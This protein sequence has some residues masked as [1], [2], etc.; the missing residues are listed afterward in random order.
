MLKKGYMGMCKNWRGTTLIS[1]PSKVFT[2]II[3]DRIRE[4]GFRKDKSCTDHVATLRIIIEQSFERQSSI[5]INSIV[6]G[7]VIDSVD[8]DVIWMAIHHYGTPARFI[9]LIHQ[10]CENF[11]CQISKVKT[12][13]RHSVT[14]IVLSR[15][16][17]G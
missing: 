5:Y 3:F 2:R 12:G 16:C 7:K 11:T 6:F 10:M 13:V 4:A 1:V 9:T 15:W 14:N 17:T 8:T